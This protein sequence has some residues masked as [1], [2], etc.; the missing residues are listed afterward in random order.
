MDTM[1]TRRKRITVS[2]PEYAFDDIRH[3]AERTGWSLSALAGE[4]ILDSMYSKPNAE[5]MEAIE[6]C[7]SGVEL[8]AVD[9][10]SVEAMTKSILG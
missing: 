4:Y 2:L 9:T 6:E 1:T 8:P 7:R 3:E 10:S 5:T